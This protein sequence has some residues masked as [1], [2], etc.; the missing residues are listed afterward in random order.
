MV[1]CVRLLGLIED[2]FSRFGEVFD[3]RMSPFCVSLS[4]DDAVRPERCVALSKVR[5]LG[6][7]AGRTILI[8]NQD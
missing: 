8:L 3:G 6:R 2:G 7:T 5:V 1:G 4:L